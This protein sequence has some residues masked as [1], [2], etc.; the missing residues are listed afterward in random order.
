M[1]K[2]KR[3]A[4]VF[5]VLAILLSN[6]MCAAVAYNYGILQWSGQHGGTSAPADVAF[7]LCIPYGG[8]MI[9]CAVIAWLF[10]EKYQKS[11]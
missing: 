11:L 6:V 2:Y 5:A 1:K 3:L 7:L 4:W 9:L 10:Q 8:G